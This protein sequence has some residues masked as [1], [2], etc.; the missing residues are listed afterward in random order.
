[1]V[2]MSGMRKLSLVPVT[3]LGAED[4]ARAETARNR[5]L[6]AWADALLA[7]LG[8]TQAIAAASTIDELRNVILDADRAEVELAIRDALHPASGRKA[9]H[10]NNLREGGLKRILRMRFAEAKK[11]REAILSRNAGGGAG[12]THQFD[13]I[14]N[15]ILDK[16]G[17]VKPVLANLVLFLKHH[18][19]WEGVLGFDEFHVQVVIHKSPP[20]GSEIPNT[21]WV[22]H[23]ESHARIWLQHE[24]IFANLG[25]V[26]RAVQAA[27]RHNVFHTVRSYFDALTWDGTSRLNDWLQTYFHV[28]ASDY[29]RAIG[30]R[31]LISAVARIYK[32]GCQ[33]DYTLILE[34]PQGRLKSEALRALAGEWFTDRISHVSSKDAALETVGVLIIELAELDA[35]MRASSSASKSFLTRRFDRLRLPYGRHQ[36]RLPRQCVFAGT[37]NPPATG[38]LKDSTGA[39][40][41]WPVTCHGRIDLDALRRD[42]DQL[43]AEAVRRFKADEVWWLE[44]AELEELAAVEQR[45]RYAT[46]IW[47]APVEE[48]LAG[49]KDVTIPEVLTKALG[50]DSKDHSQRA[51]NRVS[52]ILTHLEFTRV[53]ARKGP[54]RE[55]QRETRYRRES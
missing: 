29:A 42:R 3:P 34:G 47:Q 17:A 5:A 48:W 8:L 54:K 23:H 35:L 25:D 40:R 39:R 18:P 51:M 1:M 11:D 27:A 52:A 10:F 30:P 44:T 9:A 38:Y 28:D 12:H 41:F 49:Q 55:N 13:W 15:L 19:K 16:N 2:Q 26:G 6:F 45:A 22:D 31:Y 53:R 37:I 33:A 24:G 32:P 14:N 4:H 46:D 7:K 36:V 20:W 21:P 50:L 43:W